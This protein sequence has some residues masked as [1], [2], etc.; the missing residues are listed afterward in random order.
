M[1][2]K[3]TVIPLLLFLVC[4][5]QLKAQAQNKE[6][7][8]LFPWYVGVQGGVPFGVS[9]F[10]SFGGES[11]RAGYSFGA[12][13]GYRINPILSAELSVMFGQLGLGSSN[14]C[15][16][17][18]LGVDGVRYLTAVAGLQGNYY[19]DLYS[20]V[21]MQ[22]YGLHLNVDL[23]QVFRRNATTRW[24]VLISPAIYGVGS[25]A[26][27]K[28]NA[29]KSQL[30]QAAS[31][32]QFGVGADVSVGYRITNNLDVRLSSGINCVV[33]KGFDGM[34]DNDH[35]DNFVRNNNVSLSWRFGNGKHIKTTHITS[36]PTVMRIQ[37]IQTA[38]QP[39][40]AFLAADEPAL[41]PVIE[42]AQI[43]AILVSEEMQSA[44]TSVVEEPVSDD[45]LIVEQQSEA[46]QPEV[47]VTTEPAAPIVEEL[48][49]PVVAQAE[50]SD[51]VIVFPVIYYKLN[52]MEVRVSQQ[53]KLMQTFEILRKSPEL[54]VTIT[55]YGDGVGTKAKND[56][57][58][59][60][61]ADGVKYR[62]VKRGIDVAR[63]TSVGAGAD[64]AA[65]DRNHARRTEIKVTKGE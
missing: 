9:A 63:I 15:S 29:D 12:L 26:T 60:L 5:P 22:Q 39:V 23:M 43:V 7:E 55:G 62:L 27:I 8:Q 44:K 25:R 45:V 52:D 61:R 13:V 38:G 51:E 65:T 41:T 24:S 3:R 40:I 11:T 56:R 46:V 32:F 49:A 28:V 6:T 17:Y 53:E 42:D 33:G 35:G 4:C 21:S 10:S 30:L 57:L 47:V 54:Q 64:T 20:S 36:Q 34:P 1:K 50:V 37:A 31:Q 14:C 58:S 48:I 18:W 19:R 16:D 59:Q 2:I